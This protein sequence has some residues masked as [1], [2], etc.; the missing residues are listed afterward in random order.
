MDGMI[1]WV[2]EIGAFALDE[3]NSASGTINLPSPTATIAEISVG[4]FSF[5]YGPKMDVYGVFTSCVADGENPSIPGGGQSVV[6][7]NGLKSISYEVDIQNCF[8][9]CVINLFF[10]PAVS[11]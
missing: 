10:W 2:Q 11:F 5:L 7:R 9:A 4:R 6:I 3:G 1:V 8:A